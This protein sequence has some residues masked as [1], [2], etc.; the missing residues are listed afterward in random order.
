[1]AELEVSE[2]KRNMEAYIA[3]VYDTTPFNAGPRFFDCAAN[4]MDDLIQSLHSQRLSGEKV[5]LVAHL[6]ERS[7]DARAGEAA[8]LYLQQQMIHLVTDVRNK[9]KVAGVEYESLM[10]KMIDTKQPLF[11]LLNEELQYAACVIPSGAFP[12]PY[13]T[14]KK[15]AAP[16]TTTSTKTKAKTTTQ[17]IKKRSAADA[18]C[19][20]TDVKPKR[21]RKKKVPSKLDIKTA[22]PDVSEEKWNK[23]MSKDAQKDVEKDAVQDLLDML[24]YDD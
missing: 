8:V 20:A 7:D 9:L 16:K 12:S 10:G 19:V 3:G 11:K 1:M 23:C 6:E 4:N 22:V 13:M 5:D 14:I 15:A 21:Q 18:D 17:N 24:S 2:M